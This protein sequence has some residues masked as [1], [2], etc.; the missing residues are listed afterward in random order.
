MRAYREVVL[1]LLHAS[2]VALIVCLIQATKSPQI[3]VLDLRAD[4]K[5]KKCQ[6][7]FL[8][9]C[10]AL[11]PTANEYLMFTQIWG[12]ELDGLIIKLPC[13]QGA[14]AQRLLSAAHVVLRDIS[15]CQESEDRSS[16]S[17]Q[18]EHFS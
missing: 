8:G 12:N 10:S 14:C 2:G 5:S 18:S 1:G 7:T 11:E 4:D 15:S 17:G 16:G 6:K 13:S 9:K 3:F